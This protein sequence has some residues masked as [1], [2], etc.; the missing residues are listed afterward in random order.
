M[1]SPSS[2]AGRG[3]IDALGR[4]LD[5]LPSPMLLLDREG[6]VT[7]VNGSACELL[8]RP[9]DELFAVA[10][11]DLSPTPDRLDRLL[12]E[13]WRS[14]RARPARI[15]LRDQRG[16]IH[17]LAVHVSAA[18]AVGDP[19]AAA[20]LLLQLREASAATRNFFALSEQIAAQHREIAQ[21]R[22]VEL[23]LRHQREWLDVVLNSIGDAVLT[24]SATGEVTWMNPHA[25][26]LTGWKVDEARGRL[27]WE[28]F[29]VVDEVSRQPIVAPIAQCLQHG[30]R[31]IAIADDAVLLSREGREYGIDDSAAPIRNEHGHVLGVV[32][33]FHD[34]TEQRRLASEVRRR[35]TY[36]SLTG[37]LNR[38]GLEA[39]LGEL[40]GS[41]DDDSRH[42]LIHLDL[43]HFN[44]VNDTCGHTI[45]DLLLKRVA[46]L[47]S[48]GLRA[49][50]RLARLGAD[51]FAIVL[52]HC[53]GSR[54]R[55]IARRICSR[56]DAQR[57]THEGRRFRVGASLGLVE[58]DGRWRNVS[59]LMRAA[60]GACHSAKANGGNRVFVYA[61]TD[62]AMRDR[63]S[64]VTWAT[65]LE[66]ALDEDRFELLGQR[67]NPLSANH[68]ERCVEVLLRMIDERGLQVSP[69]HFMPAAERYLL[70]RRVDQWVLG[71]VLERLRDSTDAAGPTL[72][73]N[74][75]G[76]S[77]SD[78]D[79]HAHALR[80]VQRV[81]PE[82]RRR[83]V[84]EITETAAVSNI[85]AAAAFIRQLKDC[86][87]R[88]AL[89]DFG[90]GASSFSYFKHLPAAILKIDAQFVRNLGTDRIDQSVVRCFVEIADTAGLLTVAEGVEHRESIA[91]LRELGVDYAQGFALHRPEALRALMTSS[92]R[93]G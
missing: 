90:A 29:R 20:F 15:Q 48:G 57:F 13:G 61:E 88:V 17:D 68:E 79:F 28:V 86:E 91:Q 14:S 58:I 89:D 69:A 2:P 41:A 31:A 72:F 21:R 85:A 32:V 65:A 60:D 18:Q 76:Q 52:Q 63:R 53:E 87:V 62:Q 5:L 30:G 7:A 70:A 34:V 39:L 45:G 50:D 44:I 73:V 16:H 11:Q 80:Q 4:L 55:R 82:L 37:L 77:V 92:R 47:I 1:S 23:E 46:Q 51:E 64:R 10:L 6:R 33:A 42:A 56:L 67:I 74:L 71:A 12:A 81:A 8:A 40:L 35:A 22:Q 83:L 26:R 49:G 93:V 84:F 59:A 66:A 43:D 75:S 24:A 38:I 36:D 19:D 27:L 78:G 54:A 3:Q 9:R 25:E